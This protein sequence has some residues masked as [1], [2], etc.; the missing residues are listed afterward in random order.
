RLRAVLMGI[1]DSLITCNQYFR[2]MN[3][4]WRSRGDDARLNHARVACRFARIAFHLLA[5][6]QVFR[7]P[8]CRERSYILDKLL[9]FHTTHGTPL[10]EA[11]A[12]LHLAIAQIPPK[13]HAHEA[14]PLAERLRQSRRAKG[15]QA[16]GDLIAL[17]L[18]RLGVGM[19][20]SPTEM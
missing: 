5:G 11:L 14:Q 4:R 10:P 19:V 9:D 13:E 1:A 16:L 15:P 18:A 3:A 6:N 8:A 2:A 20:Q 7:H 12:D 17:V